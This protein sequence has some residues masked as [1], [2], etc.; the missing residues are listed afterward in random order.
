ML[1]QRQISNK[2]IH[3]HNEPPNYTNV[4]TFSVIYA[5]GGTENNKAGQIV[6]K[7]FV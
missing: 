1:D 3:M 6:D 4:R 5:N 7:T 2:F